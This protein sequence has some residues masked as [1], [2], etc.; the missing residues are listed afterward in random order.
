M[1]IPGD[2]DMGELPR[3]LAIS[4]ESPDGSTA[5]RLA[6]I[7]DSLPAAFLY[8]ATGVQGMNRRV[9]GV[10]LDIRGELAS[11]HQWWAPPR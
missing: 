3:V 7:H 1:G 2:L 6:R 10:H 8:Q 9:A 5:E 4:G 11:V